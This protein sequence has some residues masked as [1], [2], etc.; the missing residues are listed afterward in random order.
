MVL[1]S[2]WSTRT[3]IGF[4]FFTAISLLIVFS[5]SITIQPVVL[6][7]HLEALIIEP[8]PQPRAEIIVQ[9]PQQKSSDEPTCFA[10]VKA[11]HSQE[12]LCPRLNSSLIYGEVFPINC[13]E[14]DTFSVE[15]DCKYDYGTCPTYCKRNS[16]V[17]GITF[18]ET[19]ATAVTALDPHFLQCSKPEQY[20]P[21]EMPNEWSHYQ[22]IDQ[23]QRL[24]GLRTMQCEF[25]S[26]LGRA[27][28]R[29]TNCS[30]DELRLPEGSLARAIGDKCAIAK[31]P[32]KEHDEIFRNVVQERHHTHAQEGP[33]PTDVVIHIRIGD[34][35]D[36]SHHSV[37]ELLEEPRAF[38]PDAYVQTVYVK[39]YS[40]YDN[41]IPDSVVE[42]A[43]VHLVG[44]THAGFSKVA[45]PRLPIK[46]CMYV[47]ALQ[48]YFLTQRKAR[49]VK[50]RLGQTPDDDV[51]FITQSKQFV[52][53]GG[54]FSRVM[55][56][57]VQGFGGTVMGREK[58]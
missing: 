42:G 30:Y 13:N 5:L 40:Y 35:V 10:R 14:T 49:N 20:M 26:D 25:I 1:C 48:E 12:R 45:L 28:M 46:S 38:Y 54:G 18:Q 53:G 27:K 34:V 52:Q 33:G 36:H 47:Q 44:G 50:L 17:T 55:G 41:V 23:T 39:P 19:A 15:Q 2:Q 31:Y 4:C 7:V 21:L 32:K 37:R 3:V 24:C 29:K 11:T 8:P 16:S 56:D 22:L 57:L 51:L 9:Q 43:T 58:D 6:E